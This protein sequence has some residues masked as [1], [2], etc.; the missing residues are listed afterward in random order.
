MLKS[1]YESQKKRTVD[2]YQLTK[3]INQKIANLQSNSQITS[4]LRDL[5][6]CL[7]IRIEIDYSD[8]RKNKNKIVAFGQESN[9]KLKLICEN[10]EWF[11]L[12]PLNDANQYDLQLKNRKIRTLTKSGTEMNLDN[13][14]NWEHYPYNLIIDQYAQGYS[15]SKYEEKLF[16][17]LIKNTQICF[18]CSKQDE[19]ISCKTCSIFYCQNCII[20]EGNENQIIC[21]FCNSKIRLK[22]AKKEEAPQISLFDSNRVKCRQCVN[23]TNDSIFFCSSCGSFGIDS[24]KLE[25]CVKCKFF[26]ACDNLKK[27]M[28]CSLN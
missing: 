6:Q 3:Y 18:K 11:I 2:F 25:K 4:Y 12:Y 22:V 21:R 23:Q 26:P 15:L 14:Q 10:E 8:V 1:L 5:S 27:C 24:S 16:L 13:F 20:N 7:S 28:F 9:S 17:H 19:I